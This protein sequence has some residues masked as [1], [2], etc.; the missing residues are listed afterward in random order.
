[1]GWRGVVCEALWG[2]GLLLSGVEW[3]EGW[4]SANLTLSG[5]FARARVYP[6]AAPP[7]ADTQSSV[8]A[9][10]GKQA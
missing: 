7:T 10:K 1:M 6:A 5:S 3:C 4:A 9:G 2:V 8:W